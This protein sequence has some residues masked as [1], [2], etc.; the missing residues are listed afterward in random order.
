MVISENR[1]PP[2]A[3]DTSASPV[4]NPAIPPPMMTAR[5]GFAAVRPAAR[6]VCVFILVFILVLELVLDRDVI[7][8]CKRRE[9]RIDVDDVDV[10]RLFIRTT[11]ILYECVVS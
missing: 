2:D 10:D 7:H 6:R 11:T 8:R 9:F 4:V 3:D 5:C 1:R